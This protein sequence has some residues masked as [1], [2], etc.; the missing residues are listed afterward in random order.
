MQ[1]IIIDINT[2]FINILELVNGLKMQVMDSLDLS[3]LNEKTIFK[4]I[5]QIKQDLSSYIQHYEQEASRQQNYAQIDKYV[6]LKNLR[7]LKIPQLKIDEFLNSFEQ[8]LTHFEHF[9]T[10]IK[11]KN[12]KQE[13]VDKLLKKIQKKLK[14]YLLTSKKSVHLQ[15]TFLE[16]TL[17]RD[18]ERSA[19]NSQSRVSKINQV[20]VDRGS[21]S[22]TNKLAKSFFNN[23]QLIKTQV[24]D[25]NPNLNNSSSN[26]RFSS[27]AN[28]ANIKSQKMVNDGS[29]S[30]NSPQNIRSIINNL[31]G[32]S[33]SKQRNK[34]IRNS[35]TSIIKT[36]A[37]QPLISQNSLSYKRNQYERRKI[38]SQ[39][40]LQLNHYLNSHHSKKHSGRQIK[41]PLLQTLL[42]D[43]KSSSNQLLMNYQR[44]KEQVQ[45]DGRHN[46][47]KHKKNLSN[48]N[49]AT[50]DVKTKVNDIIEDVADEE[51]DILPAQALNSSIKKRMI[52]LD[53]NTNDKLSSQSPDKVKLSKSTTHSK[54]LQSFSPRRR[55]FEN[56]VSSPVRDAGLTSTLSNHTKNQKNTKS[57]NNY[58]SLLSVKSCQKTKKIENDVQF[59]SAEDNYVSQFEEGI[60]VG[61]QS[62]LSILLPSNSEQKRTF[63]Q[64]NQLRQN[65]SNFS[66]KLYD[67]PINYQKEPSVLIYQEFNFLSLQGQSEAN[68]IYSRQILHNKHIFEQKK[69]KLRVMNVKNLYQLVQDSMNQRMNV[70]LTINGAYLEFISILNSNGFID[71]DSRTALSIQLDKLTHQFSKALVDKKFY[72][73][74]GY[75]QNGKPSKENL[76]YDLNYLDQDDQNPKK[77]YLAQF[78]TGLMCHQ[79]LI[80]PINLDIYA[81]GG[82]SISYQGSNESQI[83]SDKLLR[84]KFNAQKRIYE[85]KWALVGQLQQKR[86]SFCALLLSNE[87]KIIIS[88]GNDGQKVLESIEIYDIKQN[89]SSLI[90][91]MNEPRQNFGCMYDQNNNTIM[92]MGGQ[93]MM[94]DRNNQQKL[95]NVKSIELFDLRQSKCSI[96]GYIQDEDN[97]SQILQL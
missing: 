54:L 41:D 5:Q 14:P 95:I 37:D 94:R 3:V 30:Q 29:F 9:K 4:E 28:K 53:Q 83:V 25:S 77:N 71:F 22:I 50:F 45:S 84:L 21:M 38:S 66:I 52:D 74:G 33:D 60:K 6:Y 42:K 72:I 1:R 7:Q 34:S 20:Y 75:Y 88:G 97:I 35:Q 39:S 36:S 18:L 15:S 93:K 62:K 64:L 86:K 63:A 73:S 56:Q 48:I 2:V 40:N 79:L 91:N 58:T 57:K 69:Q 51:S 65:K 43:K 26:K 23:T 11:S 32:K 89:Y 92:I 49:S 67:S 16:Q 85:D 61:E 13:A 59:N 68:Q 76:M 70:L 27:T 12:I 96:I 90:C 17:R 55:W 10:S 47:N 24:N 78:E 44:L 81:I 19:S 8:K 31:N 82:Q 80:D 87:G 46:I